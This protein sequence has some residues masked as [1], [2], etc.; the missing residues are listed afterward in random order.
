MADFRLVKGAAAEGLSEVMPPTIPN[1]VRPQLSELLLSGNFSRDSLKTS[2]L[3]GSRQA[4]SLLEALTSRGLIEEVKEVAPEV[5]VPKAVETV[6]P[7]SPPMEEVAEEVERPTAETSEDTGLLSPEEI[8]QIREDTLAVQRGERQEQVRHQLAVTSTADEVSKL[9]EQIAQIRDI[10]GWEKNPR[11]QNVVQDL[12]ARIA[13][14]VSQVGDEAVEGIAKF[15]ALMAIVNQVAHYSRDDQKQAREALTAEDYQRLSNRYG[16]A[17]EMAVEGGNLKQLPYGNVVE[18]DL[19]GKGLLWQ[20]VMGRGRCAGRRFHAPGAEK[21]SIGAMLKAFHNAYGV[22]KPLGEQLAEEN[23]KRQEEALTSS[24]LTVNQLL[25]DHRAGTFAA[26]VPGWRLGDREVTT[27]IQVRSD[28]N[29]IQV[30]AAGPGLRDFVG[31]EPFELGQLPKK[32]YVALMKA[33]ES[34][35]AR[36]P[37]AAS[38]ESVSKEGREER[39]RRKGPRRSRKDEDSGD[40]E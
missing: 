6:E 25:K 30:L 14:L 28:G 33:R 18:E 40:E 3:I 9:V 24:E 31:M 19:R 39:P 26:K 16:L 4:K 37:A 22:L 38:G 23:R 20:T 7:E 1:K 2:G 34:A 12:E 27:F 5:E 11:A 29:R 36:E 21:R 32:L 10:R 13:K 8:E 15:R 35:P 17:L